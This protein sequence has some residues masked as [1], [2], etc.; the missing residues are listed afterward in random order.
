MIDIFIIFFF[1]FYSVFFVLVVFFIGF[2]VFFY[3]RYYVG[4]GK[5]YSSYYV[6]VFFFVFSMF[7]LIIRPRFVGVFFGWDLLGLT[8]FFLII[9]YSDISSFRSGFYTFL[10][11]R[12]RDLFFLFS[13]YFFFFQDSYRFIRFWGMDL[14]LIFWGVIFILIAFIIKRA[15]YPFFSWLPIAIAAPTP[16]SSL[17][18]S[19]TLVTAGLYLLFRYYFYI[20]N[21]FFFY[22]LF[23]IRFFSI[24]YRG[25]IACGELDYKK[26]I[27]L[28]TLRQIRFVVF[29]ISNGEIYLGYIY[30]IIHAFVKSML[31][32]NFGF[33][34]LI[35][36][37]SQDSR[38]VFYRGQIGMFF[39]FIFVY[40]LIC[41]AGF[42]FFACFLIKDFFLERFLF[43]KVGT[44][45]CLFFFFRFLLTIYYGYRFVCLL[46]FS[47]YTYY[48]FFFFFYDSYFYI[49]FF[50]FLI[51]SLF[52]GFYIFNFFM[53]PD[54]YYF[55]K[56]KY[57]L[58]S[59]YYLI[60]YFLY[61]D[62]LLKI[63]NG[64]Y[65]TLH[66]FKEMIVSFVM[67]LIGKGKIKSE[68][69]FFDFLWLE[70]FRRLM[71]KNLILNFVMIFFYHYLYLN[72]GVLFTIFSFFFFILFFS[73]S[74]FQSTMLKPWGFS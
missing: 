64:W 50:F 55:L 57:K 33:L 73:H 66:V 71:Y 8:S 44:I 26:L 41:M 13:F 52:S 24:I 35:N 63:F 3:S 20:F 14:N 11:N 22:V 16:V 61:N 30:I 9:Y 45:F 72:L 38:L 60:F 49:I 10:N 67:W 74:F 23:C 54:V 31:F 32:L 7:F 6:L 19:S 62:L 48:R 28:S 2:F 68:L 69:F 4:E 29:M 12:L 25:V 59:F 70:Y 43:F 15:Q 37:G 1:D 27:A 58:L 5:I 42:P 65:R 47:L 36:Y 34:I 40:R 39:F 21:I 18:H 56:F 17:V 46:Y 53:I 51:L